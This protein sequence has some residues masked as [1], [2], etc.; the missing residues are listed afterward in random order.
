MLLFRKTK[1]KKVSKVVGCTL[2]AVL[3]FSSGPSTL[4]KFPVASASANSAAMPVSVSN[5]FAAEQYPFPHNVSYPHGIMPSLDRETLNR[6]ML[7]MYT[8]WR[9][10]YITTE[11]AKPG[12]VRIR[13]SD[14]TYKNGTCSEGMGFAMLI[15]VYMANASNSGHSDYDG[16]LR[17]Y[18]RSLSP[19]YN[20]MGWKVDKDGNSIDPYS[21]PDGDLDVAI[22]L[23]MAHKQWGSGGE[24]NYLEEANKIIA[25]IMEHLIYKPS[26]IVKQSQASI[27][28]VISSYEIPGW[29]D[30]FGEITG[31]TRWDKVTGAAY[32]IFDHFYNLNPQ[33]GL[34]PYRWVLSPTGVPTYTGPNG[35]DNNSTSYGFDPSRLPWRVGQDFLWNGT[36]NND[37]AHDLPDRNVKWFMTKIN[38]NPATAALSYNIDGSVRNAGPSPR[39]MVGPMAVAAMVD[40]SNQASLDLMYNYLRTL[41]PISDWPGGYYQDAVMMMSMLVLTGNMPNLYDYAPYPNNTLPAPLPVTDTVP[42]TKPI[43]VTVT[44]STYNTLDLSWSAATDDQGPVIYEITRNGKLY[45]VTPTLATKMEYL[46]PGTEYTFSVIA[47]D[48]A[49]N[50]TASDEVKGTTVTDTAAPP[51]TTGITAQ[52]KSLTSIT[53]RWNRPADNDT[54]NE[55]SYDVLMN[56]TKIND[57]PVYFTN[58]YVIKNLQPATSYRFQIVAKDLTGNSSVSDVFSTSTTATDTAKPTRPSYV[59]AT[60]QTNDSITLAWNASLDDNPAGTVTYDVYNSGQKVNTTPIVGTSFPIT[61][62]QPSTEYA[63]KVTARD[64]AGN[65]QDS[66]IYD[67]KTTE[68]KINERLYG[69]S[70]ANFGQRLTLQYGVNS[71]VQS[72]VYT[73]DT[74]ISYDPAVLQF[75]QASSIHPDYI[76]K[77]TDTSLPGKVRIKATGVNGAI[78]ASGDL[79][80]ITWLPRR[81]N[82]SVTLSTLSHAL[83][84]RNEQIP[85]EG[86]SL[87]IQVTFIPEDVSS[88]GGGN[89]DGVVNLYDLQ[90]VTRHMN[91][92]SKSSDWAAVR[93]ADLNLNGRIDV[94][95]LAA[96]KSKIGH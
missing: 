66:Y 96:V 50:K 44:K 63:F 81:V 36:S 72:T 13:A 74:V 93:I 31:D 70:S 22:S 73:L 15:T 32:D 60:E 14:A 28:S 83:N 16:L 61:N 35:P 69:P 89:P 17:Y 24:I 4:M 68:V 75:S 7:S 54:I 53:L 52:A 59:K 64:A 29:F 27:T 6:D 10:L 55:L 1:F 71:T 25:D 23:L 47:R 20:F 58:D 21:A 76:I 86:A 91:K 57:N 18:K 80:N 65:S 62:L 5:S 2:A 51:K 26:Y 38:G 46:D 19:G 45:N 78:P 33:T 94:A 39:N 85:T 77:E 82:Q 40:S 92:S 90:F 8:K 37:L 3:A 43:G 34:V 79:A 95:D 67:T 56:G 42:P 30:L 88:K 84:Q 87:T 49:G 12:E 9:D 41:E 48:K 11:G